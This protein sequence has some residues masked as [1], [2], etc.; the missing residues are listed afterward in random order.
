MTPE[1]ERRENRLLHTILF[2]FL[3]SGAAAQLGSLM[4]FLRRAHGLS[5]DFSGFLLSCQSAGYLISILLAGILP[6]YLGRRR[7]VL[8]TSVWMVAAYLIFVSG[9][10]ASPLL[11]AACLMVGF[12]R[13]GNTNFANTMVSTLS[14][15]RATRGF[16][17][18]HGAFAMGALLSP[19]LLVAAANRWPTAGWRMVA[20]LMCALAAIQVSIYG[21]MAL[22]PEAPAGGVGGVDKR[23]LR[24]K[25]YWLSA[26]ML[27]FYVATEFAI[28][29]WLVTYFQD[30]GVLSADHAQLM[31]SLFW[32][33][34]FAGRML[35]AAI[36]G[37]VSRSML[38]IIDGF[39]LCV[40]FTLMFF[41][42]TG[43]VV[44]PALAGVAFFMAT[45]YP[46]AFAFGS[47]CIQGNDLGCSIMMFIG[48]VGGVLTPALVGVVAER[49]GIAAGMG[50]VLA[51]TVLL[52]C[53]ILLSVFSV[54]RGR[55]CVT[56]SDR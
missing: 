24:V 51:A 4:P 32:V 34:M 10:G 9:L 47:N 54:R 7:T 33:M 28:S 50:V 43:A 45:I 37:K 21:R 48:A 35:G 18:L 25:T 14:G 53:S 19:M 11:L 8:L 56:R 41:S 2:A 13:G 42:R 29:G 52:L 30:I 3:V 16:N 46:T 6:A 23:F 38:L 44:I 22:P 39:G 40:F 55:P 20:G 15:E 5:Y 1:Q 36:T 27:F 49:A 17:L 12:A 26:A 31:N